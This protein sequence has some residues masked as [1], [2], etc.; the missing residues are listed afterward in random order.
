VQPPARSA[1]PAPQRAQ[2]VAGVTHGMPWWSALVILLLVYF[3]AHYAFA[4]IT[5][6][7]TAMYTPFLAVMLAVGA[8]PGLAALSLAYGSNLMASLTHY[9]TTPGPI[10]YGA[11]YVSQPTWW[12]I[13]L[14]LSVTTLA[15]WMTIG[16]AWWKVLGLW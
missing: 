5:A 6:H 13:G 8:P 3:Y 4:S 7:A 14:V 9:G 12:R 2:S 16:V 15:I 11:G 10:Y 1:T